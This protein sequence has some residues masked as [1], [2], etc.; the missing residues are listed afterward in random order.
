MYLLF[1]KYIDLK[2]NTLHCKLLTTTHRHT[3]TYRHK[4][5]HRHTHTHTHTHT[6]IQTHR[7]RKDTHTHTNTHLLLHQNMLVALLFFVYLLDEEDH[8]NYFQASY[9]LGVIKSQ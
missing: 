3:H 9:P 4:H 5:K 8:R 1:D 7:H 2:L 6:G